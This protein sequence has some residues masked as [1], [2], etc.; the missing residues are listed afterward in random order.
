MQALLSFCFI[1][2]FCLSFGWE[3]L[4]RF[5]SQFMLKSHLKIT[6]FLSK[7]HLSL[8]EVQKEKFCPEVRSEELGEGQHQRYLTVN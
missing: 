8:D 5:Y 2:T 7:F 3:N 4:F 6:V 1:E